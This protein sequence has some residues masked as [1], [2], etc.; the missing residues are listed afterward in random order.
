MYMLRKS[1]QL[2]LTDGPRLIYVE[3]ESMEIKGEVPWTKQFPVSAFKIDKQKFDVLA[4]ES[5]RT[6]HFLADQEAGSGIWLQLIGA[7]LEQQAKGGK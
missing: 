4:S 2:I 3:P 6:Y 1:R 5:G 7:M